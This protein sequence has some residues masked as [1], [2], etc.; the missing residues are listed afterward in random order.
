MF[1]QQATFLNTLKAPLS[2]H[3]H[4][5]H[6]GPSHTR[7]LCVT[8]TTHTVRRGGQSNSRVSPSRLSSKRVHFSSYTGT[9]LWQWCQ[10]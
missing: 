6:G 3:G 8:R 9:R 5:C 1:E 2:F 10:Q 7:H 4:G